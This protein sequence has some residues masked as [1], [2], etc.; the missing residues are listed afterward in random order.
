[1]L[2]RTQISF[3]RSRKS[4]N[5]TFVSGIKDS[6]WRSKHEEDVSIPNNW[7]F[8]IFILQNLQYVPS[9]L[10]NLEIQSQISPEFLPWLLPSKSQSGVF[11][12]FRKRTKKWFY[13]L[14][15]SW[16]SRRTR[17]HEALIFLT[18]LGFQIHSTFPALL[19]LQMSQSTTFFQSSSFEKLAIFFFGTEP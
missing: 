18:Y 7:F 14:L 10:K 15:L 8:G 19:V 17:K 2:I 12:W 11:Y 1:M 3:F 13:F 4:W 6:V 16:F 5:F 9:V